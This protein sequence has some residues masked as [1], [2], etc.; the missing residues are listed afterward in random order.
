[1][2]VAATPAVALTLWPG[3]DPGRRLHLEVAEG[4]DGKAAQPSEAGRASEAAP[5]L[6][7]AQ[8]LDLGPGGVRIQGGSHGG[9][10][11]ER[12]GHGGGYGERRG[13]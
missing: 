8:H 1:M 3:P 2:T 5:G 9:G 4:A 13:H 10:Y 11:G 6:A 7:V 12:R